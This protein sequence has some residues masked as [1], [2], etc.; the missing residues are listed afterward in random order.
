MRLKLISIVVLFSSLVLSLEVSA[1][2]SKSEIKKEAQ[3][4]AQCRAIFDKLRLGQVAISGTPGEKA[5]MNDNWEFWGSRAL[6]IAPKGK[7]KKYKKVAR[8]A[9]KSSG[10][11][12]EDV[13]G[14]VEERVSLLRQGGESDVVDL[15]SS[16]SN[17]SSS[18]GNSRS[19]GEI[20]QIIYCHEMSQKLYEFHKGYVAGYG[21]EPSA[22][23]KSQVEAHEV[24]YNSLS[25]AQIESFEGN[26]KLKVERDYNTQ[27][28]KTRGEKCIPGFFHFQ[29]RVVTASDI[30]AR[31]KARRE[32]VK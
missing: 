11:S 27:D 24:K 7:Y 30:I 17:A 15:K 9:V 5:L 16:S 22:I 28:V 8:D 13:N 25:A 6:A 21:K 26:V 29:N 19:I 2:P 23:I 4:A 10:A 14:C 12:A 1:K 32:G 20:K 3:R 31:S 18:L